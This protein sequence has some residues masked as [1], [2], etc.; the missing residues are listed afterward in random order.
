MQPWIARPSPVLLGLSRLTS[1]PHT[2][3]HLP[4]PL[5]IMWE[6]AIIPIEV[7]SRR[8]F[9]NLKTPFFSQC[10]ATGESCH[11]DLMSLVPCAASV[12]FTGAP[13]P[14]GHPAL[15]SLR[16]RSRQV[17]SQ[18]PC[19]S[20]KHFNS[21]LNQASPQN[22]HVLAHARCAIS[23]LLSLKRPRHPSLVRPAPETCACLLTPGAQPV[24]PSLE[25]HRP[26]P[27]QD[28]SFC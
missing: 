23:V 12:L 13:H 28:W 1:A 27:V 8:D 3:R 4:K 22:L 26:H 18:C 21:S 7:P 14:S 2:P 24:S 25:R 15:K 20:L 5:L 19:P 6:R 10:I 16:A 11:L 17:C 9:R